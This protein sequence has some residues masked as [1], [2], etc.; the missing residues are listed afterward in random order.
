[1]FKNGPRGLVRIASSLAAVFLL[2][3]A[4]PGAQQAPLPGAREVI[5]RFLQASGGAD[6]FKGIRSMRGRGT[7]AIPAQKMSGDV[8][9]MTARP[10]K[11]ISRVTIAGIGRLEEGFD[12]KIGWS[13][14]P[15]NGPALVVGRALTERADESWFDAPL[16]GSDYVREMSVVGREEFD[17]RSAYRVKVVLA[18]GSEQVE[19][20]DVET[21]MQIGLEATRETPF[22]S[23]PTTTVYRDY[24]KYGALNLPSTQVQRILG[25]E[26]VVTFTSYEFN[27]VPANTF[28]LPAVIKVLVK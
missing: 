20:F 8:E 25:I 1:M 2:L 16:H 23:A 5:D 3:S 14:D 4:R 18:S 22:G 10:N 26:Q 15:V 17:K 9:I 6:A 11:T 13:L 19:F 24:R 7:L 27:V 12:G 21:A 28:D